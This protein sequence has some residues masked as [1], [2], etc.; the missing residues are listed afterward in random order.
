MKSVIAVVAGLALW[1][2]LWLGGNQA[3]LAMMPELAAGEPIEGTGVLLFLIVFSAVL[4]VLSGLATGKLAPRAP[5]GHAWAL[6]GVLL[7]IGVAVQ[8]SAWTLFPVWYHVA[9]LGLIVPATLF[10]GRRAIP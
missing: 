4:S 1:T 3:L 5:L 9:F 10:G 7:A 6:A 2:V 8:A